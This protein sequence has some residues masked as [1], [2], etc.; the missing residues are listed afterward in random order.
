MGWLI[1]SAQFLPFMVAS[2]VLAGLALAGWRRT[3][4]TGALL[5][6]VASG[7]RVLHELIGVYNLWRLWNHGPGGSYVTSMAAIGA[8]QWAGGLV[9]TVLLIVGVALLLRRLPTQAR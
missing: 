2:C 3:G 9:G 7:L 5:I 4:E 8:V 1:A 6:A